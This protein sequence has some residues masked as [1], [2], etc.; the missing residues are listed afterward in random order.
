MLLTEKYPLSTFKTC[1]IVVPKGGAYME[2]LKTIFPFSFAT[3]NDVVALVI[4]IVIYLVVG[5]IAGL[6]IGL[7]AKIPVIGILFG[8]IGGVIGLYCLVGIILSVL[9]YMKVLK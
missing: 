2:L 6:I 5:A 3:K 7:L 1:G 8:L 9:D 4:N